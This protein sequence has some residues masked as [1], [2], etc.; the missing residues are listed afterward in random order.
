MVFFVIV[1]ESLTTPDSVEEKGSDFFKWISF[2]RAVFSSAV[3][4]VQSAREVKD[5]LLE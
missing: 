2:N 4:K 3:H 1:A 5:F